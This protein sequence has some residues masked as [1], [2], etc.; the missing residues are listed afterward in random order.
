MP[1]YQYDA[2]TI[3]GDRVKGT[4]EASDEAAVMDILRERSYYPTNIVVYKEKNNLDLSMLKRVTLK[5]IALFCR[6]FSFVL[7][8]GINILR[9]LEI[10]KEQTENKK[11]KK[12]MEKV[13]EDVQRGQ[14]LSEAMGSHKEIPEMLVNMIA[15]GETSGTLDIIMERMAT[16]YDKEYRQQQKTKQAM[17]YPTVVSIFA[18]VVVIIL[19]V[20]VVPTFTG[21][22]SQSPGAK[23]P[24]PTAIVMFL[25][26]F[27]IT[28]WWLL[29]I[30]VVAI[31]MAIK[32]Y[33][34]SKEGAYEID[35]LKLKVPIFGKMFSKIYTARFARTFGTLMGS[36]VSLMQSMSICSDVVGNNVF[37]EAL[38]SS[39]YLLERGASLGEILE[40]KQLFPHMLTQMIKI[41][42][43]S[44][45]LDTILEKTAEFYD[46]EVETTI[47]R[48]NTMLEPAIIV[49]LGGIVAFIVIAIILPI[50]EL[51]NTIG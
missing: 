5:D 46:G 49:V 14:T 2:R 51:Y 38:K 28:K 33:A 32:T 39:R 13:Y 37:K 24:L 4:V 40:E 23:L 17:T 44:G 42:E 19:V 48:L 27:I 18:L 34:S 25:S 8:A 16:Y 11:L 20:K 6:Q 1:Q 7:S 50:F 30:I 15:V 45:T 41:G 26:N 31:T 36:G 21:M 22:L 3:K 9:A 43:E 29:I 35:R 12:A 47:A 10:I